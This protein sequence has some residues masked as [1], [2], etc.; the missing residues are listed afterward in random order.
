MTNATNTSPD[1][2]ALIGRTA[3]DWTGM[4]GTILSVTAHGSDTHVRIANAA[5]GG[6]VLFR[7]L[8]DLEL[9]A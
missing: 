3:S 7:H 1:F 9:A 6:E 8:E 2:S 5:R 4:T